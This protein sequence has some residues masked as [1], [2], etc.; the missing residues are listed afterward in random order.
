MHGVVTRP[1]LIARGLVGACHPVPSAAVTV[2]FTALGVAAGN[3]AGTC[4]VLAVAVLAGQLSIGWSNDRIDIALDRSAARS[5][6]PLARGAVPLRVVDTAI[7]GALV[8]AVAG[9][10]AL[11]LRAGGLHLG[12]V[13]CGW[14]YNLGLKATALSWLPYAAAFG[15]APG[16]A[17]LARPDAAP[18]A[19]WAVVAGALL[20][21]TA[22]L[23]NTLPDLLADRSFGIRGLPHRLGLRPALLLAAV[24]SVAAAAVLVIAPPGTP[25]ALRLAGLAVAVAA[26]VIGIGLAWRRPAAALTFYGTI[27]VAGIDVLLL[28]L[29]PSFT[30]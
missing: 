21:V 7:A 24:T 12:A 22:H 23:T 19:G 10:A 11:G 9:S 18:P 17:T 16:I 6:K 1:V 5:D 25:S 15:A 13:A 2:L 14:A 4:A 28:V 3:A 26:T 29:G 20:G 30:A 27:A 8:V